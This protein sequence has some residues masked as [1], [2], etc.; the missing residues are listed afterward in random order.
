MADPV[1]FAAALIGGLVGGA[2]GGFIAARLSSSEGV[3]REL[4]PID[5]KSIAA[6][7]V[8]EME[9]SLNDVRET[10]GSIG[11]KLANIEE[12][13]S[14]LYQLFAAYLGAAAA[15]RPGRRRRVAATAQQSQSGEK[16]GEKSG[17]ER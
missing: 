17:E 9:A 3:R 5:P 2:I 10:M 15:Y 1:T 13:V 8:Q 16:Q 4:P 7:V 11:E 6:I 14:S 12:T